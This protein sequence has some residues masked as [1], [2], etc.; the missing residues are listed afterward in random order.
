M[1]PGAE[2][3]T[4]P[5]KKAEPTWAIAELFP[6]QGYWSEEDYLALDGN[7]LLELSDG[8]LEVLPMPTTSHQEIVALFY[9]MLLAFTANSDLGKVLFAPLPVRL[10]KGKIREPD[11]VFLFKK[12][13]DRL[14]EKFWKGADLVMEVVSG[15]KADRQRDLVKK[16]Q[17]YAKAKIPEYWIIDPEEDRITVLRLVGKRYVVHGEFDKGETATS[18]LLEGFSVDV[19]AMLNH[20]SGPTARKSTRKP[21]RPSS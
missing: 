11:V 3:R 21:K 16:R 14:G 15:G 5:P 9:G 10:W 17:D 20:A 2:R 7:H 6:L 4:R 13:Y 8:F 18:H 1:N 19:S 12:H